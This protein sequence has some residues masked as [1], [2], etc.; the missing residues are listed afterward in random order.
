[1]D[2]EFSEGLN[3]MAQGKAIASDVS[4]TIYTMDMKDNGK[5]FAEGLEVSS[6]Y[7]TREEML[8]TWKE[9]QVIKTEEE[10]LNLS[11]KD[12][13]RILDDVS[14]KIT[15]NNTV[16]IKSNVSSCHIS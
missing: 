8:G 9:V 11:E 4:K 1:M 16:R 13:E 6:E 3:L 14:V 12:I 15:F 7:I 10:Y 2:L 5:L